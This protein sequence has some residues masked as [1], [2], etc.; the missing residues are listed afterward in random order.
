MAPYDVFARAVALVGM[1]A[2]QWR[3]LHGAVRNAAVGATPRFRPHGRR[4]ASR[5]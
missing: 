2:I 1:G 3:R 5:R 4:A